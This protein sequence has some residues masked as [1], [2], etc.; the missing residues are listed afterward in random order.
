MPL[1]TLLAGA[2]IFG[3][4]DSSALSSDYLSAD[5]IQYSR[6]AQGILRSLYGATELVSIVTSSIRPVIGWWWAAMLGI[7]YVAALVAG[8]RGRDD[9]GV[10]AE[11]GATVG[12]VDDYSGVRL[13]VDIHGWLSGPLLLSIYPHGHHLASC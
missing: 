12:G 1:L 8:I 4:C 6:T 11:S 10:F 13:L 5:N 9:Q 7:S 3:V 2:G